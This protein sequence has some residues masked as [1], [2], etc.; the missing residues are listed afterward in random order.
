MKALLLLQSQRYF[1][2]TKPSTAIAL[3][4]LI[5]AI[6]MLLVVR[7]ASAAGSVTGA[8]IT[9]IGI[10]WQLGN[11]AFISVNIPVSGS[12]ACHINGSWAFVLPLSTPPQT[13]MLAQLLAARATQ[14][15]VSLQ[16]NGLC[17]TWG[18]VETLVDIT[19]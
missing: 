8:V 9:G 17:D 15:P 1:A 4:K 2:M 13:S 16:G 6:G 5:V 11:M 12:P 18:D 14:T 19:M 7:S 3:T 10:D